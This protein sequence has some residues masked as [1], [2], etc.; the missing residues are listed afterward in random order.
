MRWSMGCPRAAGCG[1]TGRVGEAL[2]RALCRAARAPPRRA[3]A[4]LPRGGACRRRER[5]LRYAVAAAEHASARLAYDESARMY[6]RALGALELRPRRWRQALRPP[7]RSRRGAPSGRRAW[8][9]ARRVPPGRDARARAAL[10]GAAG[11]G[12]AR[13]RRTARKLR[14]RRR[15]AR[16]IYSKRPWPR[17]A[18]V[19]T[20]YAR[21]YSPGWRWSCTSAARQNAGR[22]WSM[23]RGDR[24][25]AGRPGDG[26][27]CLERALRRTLGA[28]RT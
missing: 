21:G 4:S 3:R 24:A 20:P 1:C 15:G 23:R 7:A 14:R 25:A 28:R 8:A 22:P 18:R 2:E 19:T 11:A 17:S 13:L 10:A 6:E 27:V 9:G 26:R 5:G 16:R 12:G